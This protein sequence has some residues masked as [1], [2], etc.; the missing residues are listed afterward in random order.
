MLSLSKHGGQAF[1][2]TLRQAQGD[3]HILCMDEDLR[4]HLHQQPNL[5]LVI[6]MVLN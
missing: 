3:T 2:R 1:T 6:N 5:P 4:K